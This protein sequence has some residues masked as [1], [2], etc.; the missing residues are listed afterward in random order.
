MLVLIIFMEP[1]MRSYFLG[2]LIGFLMFG[3]SPAANAS[4]VDVSY[5]VSGSAGNWVLDFSVTNNLGGTNGLYVFGVRV[6]APGVV[7]SP[8]G[9]DPNATPGGTNWFNNGGSATN[10]NANWVTCPAA[11]CP[12]GHPIVVVAPGQTLTGFLVKDF[13]L[14]APSSVSWYTIAS[15]GSYT[16]PGCSFNCINSRDNPGLEG[17]KYPPAE[18]GALGIGPL[19]A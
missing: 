14:T 16:G 11:S 3:A 18:P 7:G 10:Y 1:V 6:E 5:T 9:W 13:E 4:P 8:T 19:E 15:G 12:A 2:A 17:G